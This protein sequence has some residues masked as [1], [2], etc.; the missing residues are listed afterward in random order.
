MPPHQNLD[1]ITFVAAVSPE[2]LER[3]FAHFD[4]ET[5][6]QGWPVLNGAAL[7]QFLDLPEN[8]QFKGVVLEEF[9]R[10]ND[11][12]AGAT[13]YLIRAYHRAGLPIAQDRSTQELAMRLFLE[14]RHAFQYAWSRYLLFGGSLA[15]SVYP[16]KASQLKIG[17]RAL[18]GFEKDIQG[19]F[20]ANAKG[21]CKVQCFEDEGE[22][23][24]L[25][26]R[27]K[28]MRTVAQWAGDEISFYTFRPASEDVLVYER[29]SGELA[30]KA[31]LPKERTRYLHAFAKWIC[32]DESLAETAVNARLFS[33]LPLQYGTF[34]Y[35]GDGIITGVDLAK[36]RLI[37][38]NAR[39]TEV[40]IKSPDVKA[41]MADPSI[42]LSLGSGD[43]T[44]AKFR[45]TIAQEG[46][47]PVT[48]TFEIQPP[49]RTDLGEK[50]YADIIE[51][52]LR[53]QEVRL[54]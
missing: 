41:D 14:D 32:R 35:G 7:Q 46:E 3:Y 38:P 4:W 13:S 10:M 39:G 29:R 2:I 53:E 45:F 49:V 9:R 30:I 28:Y 50:R 40:T 21:K 12:S 26:S 16:L 19:W 18:A 8:A 52:Y 37:L 17:K 48:V 22:V 34:D 20:H 6:P 1:L 11:V 33:L 24:I 27:G 25:V 31:S 54:A 47:K 5:K 44:Y 15:L 23:V 36:V 42:G 51:A 43:L